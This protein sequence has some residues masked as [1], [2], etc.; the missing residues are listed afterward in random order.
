MR[1]GN[2]AI[3]INNS[4]GFIDG[5]PL[6][7]GVLSK[8]AE[9]FI[10]II[11]YS[12]SNGCYNSIQIVASLGK[13]LSSICVAVTMLMKQGFIAEKNDQIEWNIRLVNG[14]L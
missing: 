13:H 4:P 6:K 12:L 5:M 7:K 10:W 2:G 3:T 1:Q 11:F 8:L 14:M 9:Y